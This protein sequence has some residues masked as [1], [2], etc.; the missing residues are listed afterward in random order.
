MT[1]CYTATLVDVLRKTNCVTLSKIVKTALMKRTAVSA[2]EFEP[3]HR[4]NV[5]TVILTALTSCL[6]PSIWQSS[7]PF[8]YCKPLTE[9]I[10]KFQRRIWQTIA[11]HHVRAC[12]IQDITW[13]NLD[14]L[15]IESWELISVKFGIKVQWFSYKKMNWKS[16][17][18]WK[19][20]RS[21]QCDM[22][23]EKILVLKRIDSSILMCFHLLQLWNV[24]MKPTCAI[25]NWAMT[26]RSHGL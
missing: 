18:W 26:S 22:F 4:W 17:R 9:T 2:I 20:Y 24:T 13:T 21:M 8:F 1:T 6:V 10:L 3:L 5:K 25:I 7:M 23:R 14:L 11:L 15:S 12:H 16:P 19:L